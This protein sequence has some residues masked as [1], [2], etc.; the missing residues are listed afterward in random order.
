MVIK[1]GKFGEFLACTGYPECKTTQSLN[2]RGPAISSGVKCPEINCD[3]ELVER[4]SKRGKK[5]Y[6][7][8]RFPECTF[9][10]WE[11]PIPQACPRCNAPFIVEKTTKKDGTF[12]TC[13]NDDC[14]FKEP[15]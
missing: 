7:C 3:G 2:N 14:D 12:L 15:L 4:T 9:A 6:G 8:S 1:R 11:K 5:F 10:L 13:R